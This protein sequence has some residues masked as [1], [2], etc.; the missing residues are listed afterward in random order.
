MGTKVLI[1][2]GAGYI[3]SHACV[4]LL[5]AGY[6]LIVLDNMSNGS[7]AALARVRKITGKVFDVVEGDIRDA[8]L[9]DNM[10]SSQSI[11]AVMHFAGL[12]A[13]GESCAE[14]LLYYD[15][16][17][18][19]TLNLC[20][21]MREHGVGNLVFSSSA[22]VYGDP[23]TLPIPEDHS[24]NPT[25]P[26]GRTKK[27]VENVLFDLVS[28]DEALNKPFWHIAVLRYF[29]PIGAHSSGLI[30]EAPHGIPNNLLPYIAQV[31]VGKLETLM[32]YGNDWPTEDGT[33]VRD[34]VHVMDLVEGHLSA[35][36]KLVRGGRHGCS[37]W[38]LGT[39]IGYSVLQVIRAF[40]QISGKAVP[41]EIVGRRAGDIAACWADP[42]KAK[43]ELDWAA[44]RSLEHMISDG[45]RW[46]ST[47]PRGY[48]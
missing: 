2:G 34:Y 3:G 6:E 35:L 21:V 36:K 46:Q 28:A 39:G 5:A 27:V 12:K 37:V 23:A 20:Q 25:N 40:E 45:W 41:Y 19:G 15:V 16:N 13:V 1:T 43:S 44:T 29:N 17:V 30:G 18:G 33:G 31:A 14:P 38:N 32:V 26:Y 47:N 7:P 11:G 24:L 4:T 42:A 10:F 9:L 22:T 48:E 8:E